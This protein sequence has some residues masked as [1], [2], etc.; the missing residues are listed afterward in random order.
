MNKIRERKDTHYTYLMYA[1][2]YIRGYIY[3]NISLNILK[4]IKLIKNATAAVRVGTLA[5]TSKK[6]DAINIEKVYKD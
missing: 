1:Q 3:I 5:S 2:L 6:A 4:A